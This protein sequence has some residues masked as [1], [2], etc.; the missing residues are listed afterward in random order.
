VPGCTPCVTAKAATEGLTRALALEYGAR[1]IRVNAVA[2]GSIA[3]ER[4]HEEHVARAPKVAER[5][6]RE[7]GHL[8]PAGRAGRPE[9]VA[10]TVAH[11]LSDEASFITGA[12]VPVDGGRT[13][14]THDPRP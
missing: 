11:L 10:A 2:P 3:T 13:V 4:Y 6:E 5:I 8:H 7:I 1:A 14:V 9:E 12:T